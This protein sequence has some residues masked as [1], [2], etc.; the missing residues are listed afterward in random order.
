M[1]LVQA[2]PIGLLICEKCP[3]IEYELYEQNE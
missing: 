1:K 2:M 3:E